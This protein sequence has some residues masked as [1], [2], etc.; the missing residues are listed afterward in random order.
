MRQ[1][2]SKIRHMSD[3]EEDA[4][5]EFPSPSTESDEYD[6]FSDWMIGG[7]TSPRKLAQRGKGYRS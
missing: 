5:D 4:H 7:G 3:V 2:T 1:Y 6:M